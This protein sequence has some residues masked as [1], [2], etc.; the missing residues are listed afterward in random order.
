MVDPH[1]EETRYPPYSLEE[2][3]QITDTYQ[4][5]RCMT[6]LTRKSIAQQPQSPAVFFNLEKPEVVEAVSPRTPTPA[7]TKP[8]RDCQEPVD[9]RSTRCKSCSAKHKA[10]SFQSTKTAWPNDEGLINLIAET[11]QSTVARALGVSRER[12]RQKK[13][14]I[15]NWKEKLAAAKEAISESR[16]AISE[17]RG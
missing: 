17:S 8:C 13:I 5:V 12:V 3:P 16:G 2:G 6:D 7:A 11:N 1:G 14:K 4:E 10:S 9:K 15:E